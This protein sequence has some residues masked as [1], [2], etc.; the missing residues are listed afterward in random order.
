[1]KRAA[2]DRINWKNENDFKTAQFVASGRFALGRDAEA[3]DTWFH[4]RLSWAVRW[5]AP[6]PAWPATLDGWTIV[7]GNALPGERHV[8]AIQAAI[9]GGATVWMMGFKFGEHS[10]PFLGVTNNARVEVLGGLFNAQKH[11]ATRAPY[12]VW[13][14]HA[15]LS[16]V[17]CERTRARGWPSHP[18]LVKETSR[19]E[20]RVLKRGDAPTPRV[21]GTA[22]VF[23]LYRSRTPRT[24]P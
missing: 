22:A 9:D 8:D 17:A 23:T 21:R 4:E 6:E 3:R 12:L 16:L 10:G 7:D 18:Q 24:S 15:D 5:K 20:T 11:E 2:A 13:C 1:V 19:G 14:E